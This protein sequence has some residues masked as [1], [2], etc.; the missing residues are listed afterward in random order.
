MAFSQGQYIAPQQIL[1]PFPPMYPPPMQAGF[2]PSAR[3]HSVPYY[4]ANTASR[5]PGYPQAWF[6]DYSRLG[7]QPVP[8][9]DD[10]TRQRI[11]RQV[12]VPCVGPAN[13]RS[14]Y[15]FSND[16]LIKDVFLRKKM[17]S[18]GFVPLQVLCQFHRLQVITS[19]VTIVLNALATATEV[20]VLFNSDRG[21]LVRAR[22]DPLRWVYPMSERD[23][24]ARHAGPSAAEFQS[25]QAFQHFA[26]PQPIFFDATYAFPLAPYRPSDQEAGPGV[27]ESET[28]SASSPVSAHFDMQNGQLS[29][30]ASV[31]VPNG[32]NYAQQAATDDAGTFEMQ[33]VKDASHATSEDA[34]EPLDI[35]EEDSLKDLV[36][37]IADPKDR[38]IVPALPINGVNSKVDLAES[39]R[40]I[41]PVTWR[42]PDV[43]AATQAS[44]SMS[45]KSG[46]SNL[47]VQEDM[48]QRSRPCETAPLTEKNLKK[49]NL[50][51]GIWEYPYPEFRV[52]ALQSRQATQKSKEPVLMSHL[53]QFWADFLCDY[54]VPSMYSEFM[55]NAV[56]DANNTRRTG[57]VKL[58]SMYERLLN[59]KFQAPLWNDFVRLAGEDYRNGHLSGI[60]SIW[61]IRGN[62]VSKGKNAAIQDADVARLVNGEIQKAADIDRLRREIKPAGVVLVNYTTVLCSF[63]P[64]NG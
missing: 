6:P 64:P 19:D 47:T 54:W 20:D 52:K 2:I 58:F 7:L 60:E 34:G 12:F 31:F 28:L 10:E 57:L 55:Q 29:G 46:L 63:S 9:I 26:Y 21:P 56:D 39:L 11:V 48:T 24:S 50:Q 27:G 30:D 22:H 62:V 43:T 35:L 18:Q 23:E 33:S 13:W 40:T 36:V 49:Q 5:Y 3:A 42:F 44:T 17:D 8:L 59:V 41:H 45:V 14:E 15:Y 16:N 38:P 37:I 32:V 51:S 25:N 1:Y 4:Q 61:R 53:Y